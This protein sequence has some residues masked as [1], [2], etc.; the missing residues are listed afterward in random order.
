MRVTYVDDMRRVVMRAM[1]A[2]RGAS[3]MARSA[4]ICAALI[5]CAMPRCCYAQRVYEI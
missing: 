4:A 3:A 1:R 5:T 2:E